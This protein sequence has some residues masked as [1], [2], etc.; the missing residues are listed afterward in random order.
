MSADAFDT[1]TGI[2]T[3]VNTTARNQQQQS[4]AQ[5]SQSQTD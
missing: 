1:F 2:V 4:C 5:Q 3:R